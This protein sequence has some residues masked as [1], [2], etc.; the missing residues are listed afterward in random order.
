[1][2]PREL[3]QYARE[4][5][6]NII[7][8]RYVDP[9]GA[10]Q[11]YST[12]IH[13]FGE[14]IFTDGVG[15]D[16][17]SIRCFQP[18][19]ASDM[20]LIPDSTKTFIDPFSKIK[21][22]CIICDIIDP[23]TKVPYS[24]D[25]RL[26]A[27]RAVDFMKG[28]GVAD[29]VYFGPEPEFHV[30]DEV[31]YS[32]DNH[33][34]QHFVDC[35]E[36]VWNSGRTDKPGPGHKMPIKGGYAPVAPADT[37]Q[38]F[39]G[40][41]M[42]ILADCG[43][44]TESHHHEVGAAGQCEIGLRFNPLLEMADNVMIYKYVVRNVAYQN[45]LTATFMP[46]P[47]YGDNGSGMHCHQSLWKNDQ[48]LFFDEK[49]YAGLSQ[50]A[51]NYMAGL[52]EH[53]PA[54]LAFCAPTTNSY[55][56]LVPGYEAPINLVYSQRNRSACIR[57][58][59]FSQAPKA[60]RI[61]FRAPDAS[62]NPYLAF[63]AQLMAGL[64]GIRRGLTP[65][66]PVDKDVYHL[67]PDEAAK[68]RK[69]PGSLEETLLALEKDNEFLISGGVFTPDL[70]SEYIAFKRQ[71]EILELSLRPHPYEFQMYYSS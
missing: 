43:V 67:P 3:V 28:S 44:I 51:L 50:L 26:V 30:F 16:G 66:D 70:L 7:D 37:L 64:D 5:D 20:L 10:W 39:R 71:N 29:T 25:P 55:R 22:L 27:R 47:I 13:V 52:L 21:T 36:A 46:K 31:F 35:A 59:T 49:G 2:S 61:E 33:S 4:N 57:I 41:V 17:S 65:P 40:E 34:S 42:A 6:I 54:L 11:H 1:M 9:L 58:P 45:G 15:F 12:P 23:V 48:N 63:S 8:Y 32:Q 60:K 19:E 62:C 18:I 68:I 69:T 53:A 24:R 56:R 14:D 38:D